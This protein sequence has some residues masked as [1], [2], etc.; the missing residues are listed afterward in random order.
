MIAAQAE[1]LGLEAIIEP[2]RAGEFDEDFSLALAKAKEA[3]LGGIVFGNVW[4]QDVGDYYRRLVEAAGLEHLEMLWGQEPLGLLEEFVAAGFRAVVA[5][6]WLERLGRE[7]LGRELDRK[8]IADLSR[9]DGVDPCGENGEY[10]TLVYDGPCFRE[11]LRF[12]T[13]GV[14]PEPNH[15]Y[16][17][18]RLP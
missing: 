16:L 15:A 6:V 7:F 10:H 1:A 17:D 11:P 9:L 4:L 13:C 18:L 3:G 5:S 2:T 14:H 8:F 12:A